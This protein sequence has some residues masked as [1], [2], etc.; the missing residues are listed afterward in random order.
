[1]HSHTYLG[2]LAAD[3]LAL[4]FGRHVPTIPIVESVNSD[5]CAWGIHDAQ[6]ESLCLCDSPP[7]TVLI[8]LVHLR[9]CEK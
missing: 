2:T 1:M 4:L 5:D 7:N 8:G 6:V 9:A 3:A